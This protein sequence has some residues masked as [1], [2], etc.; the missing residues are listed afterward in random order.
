[1]GTQLFAV[2][3]YTTEKLLCDGCLHSVVHY[4]MRGGKYSP[5]DLSMFEVVWAGR[6]G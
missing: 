4:I 2:A 1:M 3:Y 6:K 5:A